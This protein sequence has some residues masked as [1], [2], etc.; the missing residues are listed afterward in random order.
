VGPSPKVLK[1]LVWMGPGPFKF[2]SDDFYVH[3]KWIWMKEETGRE[4]P[5]V[6]EKGFWNKS[7]TP[8]KECNLSEN[9]MRNSFKWIK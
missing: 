2:P 9:P 5:M 3:P 1:Q 6:K 8:R 4:I 7:F